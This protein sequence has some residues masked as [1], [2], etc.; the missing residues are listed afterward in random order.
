MDAGTG[1]HM[2]NTVLENKR[3]SPS[4]RDAGPR[5]SRVLVVE[6]SGVVGFTVLSLLS[7]KGDTRAEPP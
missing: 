5:R 3:S 2:E 7:P 1:L 6:C 4:T